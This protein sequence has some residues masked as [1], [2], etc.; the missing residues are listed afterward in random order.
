MDYTRPRVFNISAANNI[1]IYYAK[2]KYVIVANSD[3]IYPPD[4]LEMLACELQKRNIYFATTTRVN[5][6]KAQTMAL[7]PPVKYGSC[8]GY[9]FV[10]EVTRSVQ[11]VIYGIGTWVFQ[12]DIILA[13][14]GYDPRVWAFEDSD[15]NERV[16]HYLRRK[17]LQYCHCSLLDMFGYHVHHAPSE[18]YDFSAQSKFIIEPRRVRL[19]RDPDSEED[20]VDTKLEC[21]PVLLEDLAKIPAVQPDL[22]IPL[23]DRFRKIAAWGARHARL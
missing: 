10:K 20:V 1:G 2:G 9:A 17:N 23:R 19:L 22:H 13:I 21:L 3:I 4:Y 15:C 12:R 16:L 7:Q 18:L 14:G 8:D 11:N 5:L 6:S